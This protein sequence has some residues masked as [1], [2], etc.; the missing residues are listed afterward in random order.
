MNLM[1][2]V[3]PCKS[4]DFTP[5][6]TCEFAVVLKCEDAVRYALSGAGFFL[7]GCL[8]LG[9]MLVQDFNE[10]CGRSLGLDM[11]G[12]DEGFVAMCP[13]QGRLE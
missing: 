2:S 11:A 10:C 5:T 13:S 7:P 9:K 8:H 4:G 12:A 6:Y 1:M 3:K